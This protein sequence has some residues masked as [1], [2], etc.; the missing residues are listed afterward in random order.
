VEPYSEKDGVQIK[1]DPVSYEM[2]VLRR[3][4]EGLLEID[5]FDWYKREFRRET[6]KTTQVFP[7]SGY[8]AEILTSETERD[9]IWIQQGEQHIVCQRVDFGR[10]VLCATLSD[11]RKLDL[12]C[13]SRFKVCK[14]S[15]GLVF[16]PSGSIGKP[17]SGP[18]TIH[19]GLESLP[20][21]GPSF[22]EMVDISDTMSALGYLQGPLQD[23]LQGEASDIQLL[24]SY[25]K[26]DG[27]R[28]QS[29]LELFDLILALVDDRFAE[30][31]DCLTD[32]LPV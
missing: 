11:F 18:E 17:A 24:A 31:V 30:P 32:L 27:E 5:P 13:S 7:S 26:S 2:L 1:W 4:S 6:V 9:G 23:V 3:N 25:M 28:W 12:T 19:G 14:R 20:A 8:W 15:L 21:F 16:R 10:Y 29:R 22:L